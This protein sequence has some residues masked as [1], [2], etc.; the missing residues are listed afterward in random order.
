MTFIATI[1]TKEGIVLSA[2]SKELIQGGQLLWDDFDEILKKKNIEENSEELLIS[3]KEIQEKFKAQSKINSGRVKSFDGAKKIY[4]I[5]KHFAILIAGKANPGGQN[6]N[7]TIEQIDKAIN[8][9]GDYSFDNCL[10][11]T[12]KKIEELLEKDGDEK[13]E[14]ENLFCGYDTLNNNFRLFKFFFNTKRE[15]QNG[16]FKKDENGNFIETKYLKKIELKQALTTGG[17][18]S[19]IRDL[20]EFNQINPSL[21]LKQGF[22]LIEKIMKLAVTIEEV[23]QSITGIGGKIY[24]AII[25]KQG[26]FWINGEVDIMNRYE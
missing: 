19:C 20:G 6:Y 8:N 25:T 15:M 3:P 17:W 10:D 23:T 7:I 1:I 18:V 11:I 12:F 16:N 4:K 2:D 14:S 21:D 22:L 24:Y 5:N 13:F 26:F 9:S